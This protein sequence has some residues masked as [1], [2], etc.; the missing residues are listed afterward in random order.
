MGN[1]L[2]GNIPS[3][4]KMPALTKAW[5]QENRLSGAIPV[6]SG[7]TSLKLV[8]VSGNQLTGPTP[9]FKSKSMNLDMT[10]L[11]SFCLDVPGAPCDPRVNDLLSI[12]EGFGFPVVFAESWKGNDPCNSTNKWVGI[13]CSGAN[14]TVI[15][16]KGMALNGTI[17]PSFARLRTLKVINLSYNNLNG[18]IPEELTELRNLETIDVSYCCDGCERI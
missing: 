5:L 16:F 8:N 14:I 7:L 1:C 17:S 6:F 12:V 13:T 18:D 10:G 2:T 11:N 15:D 9:S 4:T 3:L